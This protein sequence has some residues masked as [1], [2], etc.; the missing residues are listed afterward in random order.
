MS[1][2]STYRFG[3]TPGAAIWF[4]DNLLGRGSLIAKQLDAI[5]QTNV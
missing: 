2:T 3:P 4:N 5:F 1:W